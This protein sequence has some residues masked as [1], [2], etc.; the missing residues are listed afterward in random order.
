VVTHADV[1]RL[2]IAHHAGMHTDHVQRLVVDPGSITVVV[3]GEGTARL[4]K[5][6]DTGGLEALRPRK[7]SRAKR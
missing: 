3:V 7:R 4:L 1:V 6:N 5:V 2:L